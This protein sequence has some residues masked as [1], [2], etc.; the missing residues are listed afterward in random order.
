MKKGWLLFFGLLVSLSLAST[1]LAQDNAKNLKQEMLI[2]RMQK[3]IDQLLQL[4]LQQQA[5]ENQKMGRGMQTAAPSLL[6]MW[7][8]TVASMA[9][10]GVCLNQLV[11][12]SLTQQCGNLIGGGLKIGA[13]PWIKVAGKYTSTLNYISINGSYS[14]SGTYVYIYL[15]ADYVTTPTPRFSVYSLSITTSGTDYEFDTP[16]TIVKQ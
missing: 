15:S 4:Q 14:E 3:Q 10:N 13:L 9:S 6:G 7:K 11:S 2:H 1:G 16:F 8:G 12:L 5:P